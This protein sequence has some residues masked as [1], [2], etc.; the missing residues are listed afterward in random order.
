MSPQLPT[1]RRHLLQALGLL[2][3]A[4]LAIL[5]WRPLVSWFTGKPMGAG[6]AE[7]PSPH[8]APLPRA[9]VLP[10]PALEYARA[11]IQSYEAI[12]AQL[13]QDSV[14]GLAPRAEEMA[15]ALRQAAEAA[16]NHSA[17][18]AGWLRK[19]AEAVS[20][21]GEEK[22]L[23]E[24][25]QRFAEVSHSLISLVAGDARL[26]EG[27]HVFECPMV[28]GFNKWLQ[29]GARLENPYMGQRMLACGSPSQWGP[30]VPAIS[31]EGHT[32]GGNEVAHYTCPMHPS[33]KQKGPGQCPICGMDL[34]P[35]TRAEVESGVILVDDTRRQRIG[36]KTA[37]VEKAPM[38]LSFR[39]L[40]RVT[41]DEKTLVDVTLKLDG[42][43][44]ELR[45]NAT[46]EPVKRGSVLFTLYSPEL[47]A[48]Q[49]EYLL[50]RNSQS[51]ANA[52]LV[53]AARKRLEL[54]GL[55]PA[56]IERIAQ[57]G[58]PIENMPFLSP[59]S[60]YV[61]EKNVVEGAA[62]KAGERLFRIAP[63]EKVWVEAD[64]YEQD[65]PQVKTGLPVEVTLPYLPGK[66]Y[67]GRVGYI[68]PAL[69][70]TTRTGRIRIE[71]PNP[72]LELRPDMYADVRFV[73]KGGQRLQVPESA[74]L[75]TGPRRIV[76]VDLGEGRLK[77]QEVKL[78]LKG[79]DT[80]EVVEGLKPGDRV[81]TSG[82]F[83][84]AAESRIRSATD[85]W[86][87]GDHAGH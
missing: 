16:E 74:V 15:T 43:I 36:V 33:V 35:V 21:L 34:T 26:Q 28:K 10:G 58:E 31:A 80:Y 57:S 65:L 42:Y 40:G 85:S 18:M 64:V 78:G 47:Y 12:R 19:G 84:I 3:L 77:P 44:H 66:K 86:T 62:V 71:L 2:A 70:G 87:G 24:A 49:Q 56:Q 20:R 13:A 79:E 53:G 17:D 14:E 41:Y 52:S 5:L 81:V 30:P 9:P 11:A 27:W 8:A 67:A 68:Y 51:A 73:V 83:L 50:A 72:G 48:A 1:R 6:S 75:Y 37:V 82:N 60:G 39:A 59:A 32:H 29:R 76:F 45:V 46:G 23:Q 63:L 61:I 7:F 25:R 38:D 55:T 22:D 4:V 54:W 69:E